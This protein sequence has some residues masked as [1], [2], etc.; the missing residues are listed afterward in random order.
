MSLMVS[1]C[2]KDDTLACELGNHVYNVATLQEINSCNESEGELV[3]VPEITFLNENGVE[4]TQPLSEKLVVNTN[5][6]L[7]FN[8]QHL[9]GYITDS[10]VNVYVPLDSSLNHN[11]LPLFGDENFFVI[12]KIS[13][14]I[15]LTSFA[16]T[17]N[18]AHG[19]SLD[20]ILVKGL[21]GILGGNTY[22]PV[23]TECYGITVLFQD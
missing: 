18:Y 10:L 2:K 15:Q 23:D 1:G 19:D 4:E 9:A 16:D 17:L 14:E 3:V 12:G 6:T 8:T 11:M 20:Y 5:D 13:N 7:Y 22:E 21:Y